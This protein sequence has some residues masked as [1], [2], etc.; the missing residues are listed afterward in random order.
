MIKTLVLVLMTL[1]TTACS[2]GGDAGA[3]LEMLDGWVRSPIPGRSNTAAYLTLK[4]NSD[5]DWTLVAVSTDQ[6]AKVE[7]HQHSEDGGMMRMRKVDS[8]TI[9]AG[10]TLVLEPGGYHLMLFD[11]GEHIAHVKAVAFELAAADGRE[12]RVL[13]PLRSVLDGEGQGSHHGGMH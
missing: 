5:S 1:L 13:L 10:E 8:V 11:V 9:A 2:Q 7:V 4:N 12:A 6:A 3:E